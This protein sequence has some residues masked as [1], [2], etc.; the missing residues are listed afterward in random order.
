MRVAV[1]AGPKDNIAAIRERILLSGEHKL[2]LIVPTG[3]VGLR[4]LVDYKLLRRLA[5]DHKL[6]LRVDLPDSGGRILA[7]QAGLKLASPLLQLVGLDGSRPESAER[8]GVPWEIVGADGV[9]RRPLPRK[10]KP[11]QLLN[12]LAGLAVL[13]VVVLVG[14]SMV[15]LF[16]PSATVMLE[17]MTQ[18]AFVQMSV[19]GVEG[20]EEIDFGKATVP[21][22]AIDL[23]VTGSAQI[24][25]TGH[26]D[27]LGRAEGE[28]VFT[29]K[30]A[31]PVVVPAG[32]VVR[33]SSGLPVRF[34]TLSDVEVPGSQSPEGYARAARVK[35]VDR[36]PSGDGEAP[37]NVVEGPLEIK[38]WV[39]SYGLRR[40]GS[41]ATRRVSTVTQADLD[42][43]SALLKRRLQQEATD[44]LMELLEEDEF[45]HPSSME[46]GRD[47]G[48]SDRGEFCIE[49]TCDR[50]IDEESDLLGCTMSIPVRALV[51]DG[52]SA[53]VLLSILMENR[54]PAG[55]RLLPDT[56]STRNVGEVTNVGGAV[57]F[58]REAA[59]LLASHVDEKSLKN[60]LR[61]KPLDAAQSYLEDELSLR[62]EPEIVILP[63]WLDRLPVLP[64]RIKIQVR[65]EE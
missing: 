16:V 28:V 4:S 42:N 7:R 37:I 64:N 15:V 8:Q 60:G 1:R 10:A 19:S 59:G 33:T 20:S 35:A 48:P 36:G 30:T 56:L 49:K 54:A 23:T 26:K 58:T 46:F 63:S 41:S 45:I 52:A 62:T 6:D 53:D 50:G 47:C 44:R 17:P 57:V 24:P 31:E 51:A 2:N 18:P 61:F 5:D 38:V 11:A 27:V 14:A 40:G 3:C 39:I 22:R 25:T 65:V 9:P 12:V 34:H 43:L 32:T 13:A 29:N 55:F 21:A